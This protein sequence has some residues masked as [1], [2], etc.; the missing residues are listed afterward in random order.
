MTV[1][2]EMDA[3]RT[4]ALNPI[5]YVVV[6]KM[7]GITLTMPMLSIISSVVGVFGGFVV[8][9][10]ALELTPGAFL[11]EAAGALRLYDL[12][13]GLIKSLVFAWLI[14]ILASYF[15][16][17]VKGGAE[18]VGRATTSA[19]VASIFGVIVADAVM[20]LLFYL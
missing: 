12:T 1:S 7:W 3:L 15:G 6:P 13:T 8:A 4:M 5:R 2:E 11:R 16:F 19:V 10:T 9:V 14:V 17:R 20:G 18:G